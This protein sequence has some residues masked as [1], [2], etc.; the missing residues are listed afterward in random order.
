[1]RKKIIL[2]LLLV[3]FT[4]SLISAQVVV[5]ETEKK[6]PYRH[7]ISTDPLA[8]IFG[9]PN[10]SYELRVTKNIAV[11]GYAGFGKVLFVDIT[12]S[13]G[14]YIK[15]YFGSEP[16]YGLFIQGGIVDL[17]IQVGDEKA[18]AFYT[19]LGGGY[20]VMKFKPLTLE[21]SSGLLFS[22]DDKVM[23]EEVDGNLTK[24]VEIGGPVRFGASITFGFSF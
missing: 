3:V 19:F 15:G 8:L 22:G 2:G 23:F 5:T 16:D 7:T 1:M 14:A 17:G 10:F 24:T 13:Y 9:S 11:S 12:K 6:I 18:E 4:F 20:R 21:I